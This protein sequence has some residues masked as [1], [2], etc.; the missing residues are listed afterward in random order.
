MEIKQPENTRVLRLFWSKRKTKFLNQKLCFQLNS[1]LNFKTGKQ[2][3]FNFS[4]SS[5]GALF[6]TLISSRDV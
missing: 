4:I 5:F 6:S 2:R 3:I 1:Y